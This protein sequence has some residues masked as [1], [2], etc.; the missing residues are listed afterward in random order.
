MKR[1]RK[2]ECSDTAQG[3]LAFALLLTASILLWVSCSR[4]RSAPANTGER[5]IEQRLA[6]LEQGLNRNTPRLTDADGWQQFERDYAEIDRMGLVQRAQRDFSSRL[7]NAA[8]EAWTIGY[9]RDTNMVW[10]DVRYRLPGSAE[11][12]QKEFGY[13]RKTGTNWDLIWRV[14][15]Q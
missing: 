4:T 1:R 10:C 3:L 12:L 13:Q 5:S 7:T 6:E 14:E 8:V 9:L 2:A 15:N 11:T